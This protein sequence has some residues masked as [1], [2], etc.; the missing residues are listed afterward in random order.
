VS[1]PPRRADKSDLGLPRP[2]ANLSRQVLSLLAVFR[3]LLQQRLPRAS[4][5]E[6]IIS[7]TEH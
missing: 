5:T 1:D 2:G 6:I 4:A 7:L 3:E